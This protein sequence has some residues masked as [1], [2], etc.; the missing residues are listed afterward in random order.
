MWLP[1][2]RGVHVEST[3]QY[4]NHAMLSETT[5][6]KEIWKILAT[7]NTALVLILGC[8]W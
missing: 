7:L 6:A 4:V 5:S 2:P 8:S 1:E 3:Q